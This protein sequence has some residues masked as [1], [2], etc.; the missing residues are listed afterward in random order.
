[1]RSPERQVTGTHD[2]EGEVLQEDV[3]AAVPE[4]EPEERRQLA[5]FECVRVEAK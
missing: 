4:G 3:E 1:M 2:A 5:V